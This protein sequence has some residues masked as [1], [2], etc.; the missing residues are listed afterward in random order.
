MET[1]YHVN[2]SIQVE[3]SFNGSNSEMCN[4]IICIDGMGACCYIM[5]VYNIVIVLKYWNNALYGLFVSI[6]K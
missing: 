6:W 1:I 5:Y 2:S 4:E 3:I